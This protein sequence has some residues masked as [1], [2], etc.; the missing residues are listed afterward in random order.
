[1]T[2]S[3]VRVGLITWMMNQMPSVGVRKNNHKMLKKHTLGKI[4]I[5]KE[6]PHTILY[7]R[8]LGVSFKLFITILKVIQRI[9]EVLTEI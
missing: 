6:A 7:Y 2:D 8:N 9:I 3:C 5:L 4:V 1:M